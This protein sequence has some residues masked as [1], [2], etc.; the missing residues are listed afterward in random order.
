M[1]RSGHA[2]SSHSGFIL[3][4]ESRGGAPK[5]P[6]FFFET[7]PP[8]YLRVWMNAP[9][10][11]TKIAQCLLR[12]S[13]RGYSVLRL[14]SMLLRKLRKLR[15]LCC[16]LRKTFRW[17]FIADDSYTARYRSNLQFMLNISRLLMLAESRLG[18]AL[19]VPR[20]LDLHDPWPETFVTNQPDDRKTLLCW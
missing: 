8:P 1:K 9:T 17:T 14:S 11:T 16:I 6:K 2:V 4:H 7:K 5:G 20:F 13:I 3:S 12:I 18:W 15:K 19:F 10:T